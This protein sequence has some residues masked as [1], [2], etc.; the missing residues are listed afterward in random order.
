MT[1]GPPLSSSGA[2]PDSVG[3]LFASVISVLG[4]LLFCNNAANLP[5]CFQSLAGC[6]SRNLFPFKL[7]H[8][9][10]GVAGGVL[11]KRSREYRQE[12]TTVLLVSTQRGSTLLASHDQRS[13]IQVAAASAHLSAHWHD[14]RLVWRRLPADFSRPDPQ[15]R[16]PLRLGGHY[17][18]AGQHPDAGLR[19][20]RRRSSGGSGG[21]QRQTGQGN[22]PGIY[23]DAPAS[24][25]PAGRSTPAVVALNQSLPLLFPG[26]LGHSFLSRGELACLG[27]EQASTSASRGCPEQAGCRSGFHEAAQGK[28]KAGASRGSGL[29]AVDATELPGGVPSSE[30]LAGRH[31]LL[32]GARTGNRKRRFCGRSSGRNRGLAA[33]RRHDEPEILPAEDRK[34]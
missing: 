17:A 2:C 32:L 1:G 22:G 25:R 13:D 23:L 26:D 18:P 34:S 9:C 11:K 3:V 12:R 5:L 29:L 30:C 33:D 7:L 19:S 8:C 20:S 31:L 27:H 6:S 4:T 15:Q 24:A 21:T 16:R 28:E 14:R 10:R